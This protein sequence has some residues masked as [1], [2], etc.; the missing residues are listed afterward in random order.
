MSRASVRTAPGTVTVKVP[1]AFQ[2]RGGRKVVIAPDGDTTLPVPRVRTDSTL[3]KA[4][5]RAHRWKRLLETGQYASVA[6]L[7]KAERINKSY[8]CRVLWLNPVGTPTEPHETISSGM[9]QSSQSRWSE[10]ELRGRWSKCIVA[11]TSRPFWRSL[12]QR[13]KSVSSPLRRGCAIVRVPPQRS[14][15]VPRCSG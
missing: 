2:R 10:S 9:E 4:L 5:A 13:S 6:D 1:L 12:V 7:A 11:A 15:L 3:V 14:A 8:L